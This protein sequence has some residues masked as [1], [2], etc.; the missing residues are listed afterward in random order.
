MKILDIKY[1]QECIVL[2]VLIANKLRN[3]ISLYRSLSQPTN[4]FDQ[5]ADNL[6]L[7]LDE[8]ADHNPFLIDLL[9]IVILGDF[10]IKSENWYK[11]DKMPYEGAKIDALTA[12]FGLQ[13]FTKEP[14]NIFTESFSCI[15][16]IFIP[17]QNLVMESGVH[18]TLH[19]NRHRLITYGKFDLK[20]H[21]PPPYKSEIWH[22]DQANV[23]HIRKA[24]DLFPRDKTLKNTKVNNVIF[25]FNKTVQGIIS[26]YIPH[27]TVAF[28]DRDPLWIKKM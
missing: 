11:H 22:Y 7:T 5:F 27:E 21:Y 6:E 2:L 15:D 23:D 8:V 10:N 25:L 20:I 18:S 28:D 4:I 3:F 16:L 14:T 24:V 26:N 17:H 12:Q 9:L 13:Q 1:L 19:P